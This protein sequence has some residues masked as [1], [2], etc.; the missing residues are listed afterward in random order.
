MLSNY[1]EG[2][3]GKGKVRA[4]AQASSPH[5]TL[6]VPLVLGQRIVLHAFLRQLR[7]ELGGVVLGL[8]DLGPVLLHVALELVSLLGHLVDVL[9]SV[10][11]VTGR[12]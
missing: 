3:E 4:K 7:L 12:G 1:N 2:G 11:P 6:Q 10:I 5:L 9:A 8:H